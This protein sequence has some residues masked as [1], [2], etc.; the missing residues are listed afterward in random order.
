M[1]DMGMEPECQVNA[2]CTGDQPYCDP[3]TLACAA[4]PR[5]G[6]LGWGD[7]TPQ[8]VTFEEIHVSVRAGEAVDVEFSNVRPNELWVVHREPF[9]DVSCN[10]FG[11]PGCRTLEGSTTTIFDPGTP[12]QREA[13]IMDFNALHFMRRPPAIAFGVDGFFATC[14]EY[15]TGNQTSNPVN[16]IGPTLWTSDPMIYRNYSRDELR[17]LI[18]VDGWNGTHYDMLHAS[19]NCTGIAH[20]TGNA[21]WVTNG[22]IGS[23]DR[24]D[25][26]EHHGPGQDDHSDGIIHRYAE[27]LITRVPHVPGHLVVHEGKVYVAD[28]G[29]GR[30]VE[31]DPTGA[32]AAGPVRPNYDRLQDTA[33][34]TGGTI[35][36][37]VPPGTLQQPSGLELHDGLLYVT[38]AQTGQFH[39]FDLQ[40]N[41]VRSLDSGL[42]PG[43]LGGIAFSP[44]GQL[45][46]VDVPRSAVLRIV[47]R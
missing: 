17:R 12:E 30:I 4:P 21:Y 28:T 41:L 37:L 35:T 10:S 20:E 15:R 14:G 31:F 39:A 13:W 43:H 19:P 3:D 25:F 8:S 1:P 27:G 6:A 2:D 36:E 16:F 24:Y 22:E 32:T 45:Y 42:P 7:G 23:L 33:T 46:F 44:E 40:G 18:Q 34:Y 38:D 5:A 26:R 29:G 47:P 11:D 9:E